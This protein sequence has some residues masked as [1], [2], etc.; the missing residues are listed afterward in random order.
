M[1]LESVFPTPNGGGAEGQVRTLGLHLPSRSVEVSIIVPMVRGGPQQ[2][3]CDV[4]GIT[5]HRI[6]YP[7][8]RLIGAAIMLVK[9]AWRLFAMRHEYDVIHA[10]IAGN[11][12]A[13]SCVMGRLLNRPAMIKFAGMTEMVDGVL[14]PR[15]SFTRRLKLACM[16]NATYYQATS[17]QIARV[18]AESG[19]DPRKVL[20]IPNAV[21]TSRF[22]VARRDAV[23]RHALCG[24]KRLVAIYVGRLEREKDLELMLT[25]WAGAFR[26][27]DGVALIIVGGGALKVQL[28]A[29]A[30]DLGI[31][32]QVVFTGPTRAV[33]QYLSLADLGLLTSKAEGLSNALLEYMASSLPV[34][35]TRVSGT[36][37]FVIDGKTG[38]LFPVGD[39]VQLQSCLRAAAALGS[40]ALAELG[41]NAKQMVMT[42]ASIAAVTDRL[43]RCYRGEA[44]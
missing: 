31:A 30:R 37:D 11:M 20:R 3:D 34:I 14:D 32:Q 4:E 24:S 12:A 23:G 25:G 16:R 1:V 15:P 43:A 13:V 28:E 39:A 21:D 6:A 38:W 19:F 5:V 27:D 10:H 22:K 41:Q 29:L 8:V 17:S 18:L 33:E 7:K 40:A 36:E 26:G 9:L 2:G 42:E 44:A 35:G